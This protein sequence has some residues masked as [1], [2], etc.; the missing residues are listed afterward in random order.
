MG[1]SFLSFCLATLFCV[2]VIQGS[3]VHE[4][5]TAHFLTDYP[6]ARCLDGSPGVYYH[7]VGT[8]EG[9]TKWY[10]HHE[11]GGWCFSWNDCRRRSSM[12]MTD[13]AENGKGSSLFDIP[14]RVRVPS[15]APFLSTRLR[16]N[17]MMR[18]WNLVFLR[19]CDGFSFSGTA[20]NVT[21]PDGTTLHFGG[22]AIR[23]AAL[24][25]MMV[26][27]GLKGATDVIIGGCSAGALASLMYC[28][29]YGDRIRSES[30]TAHNSVKVACIS[31]SG[32]FW[33]ADGLGAGPANMAFH[34]LTMGG[35]ELH[36]PE[37]PIACRERFGEPSKCMFAQ[38]L[39]P[40][41]TYPYFLFQSRFDHVQTDLMWGLSKSD[42]PIFGFNMTTLV[43]A[44]FLEGHERDRGA[45]LDACTYHCV[46]AEVHINGVNQVQALQQWYEHLSAVTGQGGLNREY[47]WLQ[48]DE[49]PCSGC[50]GV[51]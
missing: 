11:G 43:L 36:R 22:T 17:P 40:Y 24:T 39:F 51:S 49:F 27:L 20:G 4:I 50:C 29:W 37:L 46:S 9:A 28:D 12:D 14:T 38:H 3:I 44:S 32:L 19:Y 15:G 45:F 33:D 42:V 30:T 5:Y 47:V 23:E 26:H 8:G 6:Q 2:V 41:I 1:S 34:S 16:N 10:I 13:K 25:D 21:H 35:I 7:H 18:H 48:P 31:E